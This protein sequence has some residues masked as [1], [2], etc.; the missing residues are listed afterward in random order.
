M[1]TLVQVD[2]GSLVNAARLL[3]SLHGGCGHHNLAHA[4]LTRQVEHR[5]L[6]QLL[7]DAAQAAGARLA[8]KGLLGDLMQSL[9]LEHELDALHGKHAAILLDHGVLGLGEDSHQVVL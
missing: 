6:E 5:L 3:V 7:A 8:S 2:V 1:D 9:G 4:L